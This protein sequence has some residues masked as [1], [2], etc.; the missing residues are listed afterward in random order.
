MEPLLCGNLRIKDDTAVTQEDCRR[1]NL[2]LFGDPGS[3]SWIRKAL[4]NLP[5][6]WSHEAIEI[7]VNRYAA[8]DVV[9]ACIATSPFTGKTSL[10]RYI[11]LNSGHAFHE[12]ELGRLNYLLFPRLADW[13]VF[14]VG[15]KQP[16]GALRSAGRRPARD[17]LLQQ[18]LGRQ[19]ALRGP[20]CAFVEGYPAGTMGKPIPPAEPGV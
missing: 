6:R 12:S 16:P 7:G 8:S 13:A 17:R 4:P 9:P 15:E 11:V 14:A 1:C 3:N 19:A 2:I 20:R 10:G 18:E 5:F